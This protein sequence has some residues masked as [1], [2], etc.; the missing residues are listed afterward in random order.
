MKR[1]MGV[2]H[3]LKYMSYFH[4]R[5]PYR[6]RRVRPAVLSLILTTYH[7]LQVKNMMCH[8]IKYI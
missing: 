4:C 8:L 7:F 2:T 3:D 1:L 6:W 5:F